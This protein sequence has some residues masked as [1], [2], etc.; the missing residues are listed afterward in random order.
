MKRCMMALLAMTV[1]LVA[2]CGEKKCFFVT[3]DGN[4]LARLY[5]GKDGIFW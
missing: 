2:G 3:Q 4:G 5:G 1:M